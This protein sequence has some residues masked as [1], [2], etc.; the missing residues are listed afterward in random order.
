[1]LSVVFHFSLPE[2]SS[3]AVLKDLLW[4]FR[5]EQPSIPV[6]APP[7]DLSLVL[8]FL[9]S[10]TFEP[11]QEV[12]LR[13]LTKKTLFL[14]SLAT[15]CWV[16]ELQAI[17]KSLSFSGANIH[18]SY[19]SEFRA[20]TESEAN[21][22]QRSFAV[23]SLDDFVGVMEEELLLCL[24]RALRIYLQRTER[25]VPH[26]RTLFISPRSSSRPLSKNAVSFFLR[27]VISQA[28][29]SLSLP[30]PSTGT[31]AHSIRGLATSVSFLRNYSILEF[32]CWKS[33]SVVTS[34][35]LT[36]VQFSIHGGFS[37]DPFVSANAV[38][39]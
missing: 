13:Q 34:F 7:W 20:K 39:S 10:S 25:L 28:Y 12:S 15:A 6:R 37:L 23:Y 16:G 35:Y 14:L 4:S 26:P 5:L 9:R 18:L 19:L 17:S 31:R 8:Q 29:S 32:A 21:P 2:L 38:I 1:M 11:L 24:V 3:S 36:D 27:E 33:A 22:L 30:D